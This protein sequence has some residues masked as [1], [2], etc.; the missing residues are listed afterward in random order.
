[1]SVYVAITLALAWLRL[2]F[3][4][5]G[6]LAGAVAA[7]L[8][9][10]AVWERG[11]WNLGLAAPPRAAL[12]ETL[13]GMLMGVV[14]VGAAAVLVVL[15]TDV[16][17]QPGRGF[18]W[19]ELLLVF[20]PAVLHEELLFR[21]YPFQVLFRRNRLFAILF[22]AVLFAGLHARNPG[23]TTLGLVNIFFGGVLLGLAYAR[24]ER[25]W[26]PIGLH[27]AWNLMSGPISGHEVSGYESLQTVFVELGS[28]PEWLTGGEFGIEGSAWMTLVELA[29]IG[30]LARYEYDRRA[31]R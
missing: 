2:S 23:V 15:S 8:F 12:R 16:H 10:I 1:M 7:T 6:P 25:L 18:P 29:G 21:G 27:L 26:L 13:A 24:H 5:F 28:G 14:L 30:W 17:H 3:G 9:T 19:G 20:L 4:F 11:R 31:G 22:V